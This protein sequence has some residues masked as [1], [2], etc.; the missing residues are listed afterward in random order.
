MV[1]IDQLSRLINLPT[2]TDTH[3]RSA[4]MVCAL[5]LLLV[6]YVVR[7]L[8]SVDYL[9]LSLIKLY[10]FIIYIRDPQIY[11]FLL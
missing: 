9:Q 8:W 5:K 6:R 3:F 2:D 1:Q 7:T 10:L 11:F 4:Y